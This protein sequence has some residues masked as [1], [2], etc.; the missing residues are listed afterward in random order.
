MVFSDNAINATIPFSD[1]FPD[2]TTFTIDKDFTIQLRNTHMG[3]A[4][5]S[6]QTANLLIKAEGK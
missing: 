5:F 6:K 1:I 3:K 4:T 2:S